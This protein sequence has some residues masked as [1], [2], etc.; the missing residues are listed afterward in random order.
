MKY[1]KLFDS[2]TDYSD[3]AEDGLIRPNVSHCI[4]DQHVHYN[5]I[6]DPFNGQ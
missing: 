3:F 5:P 4:E 2:H 6:L 1:I